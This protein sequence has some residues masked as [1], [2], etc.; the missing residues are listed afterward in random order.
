MCVR[1][2]VTQN[3][4][5]VTETKCGSLSSHWLPPEFLYDLWIRVCLWSRNLLLR[6]TGRF[7]SMKRPILPFPSRLVS[8]GSGSRSCSYRWVQFNPKTHTPNTR[9][10]LFK[11]HV[12]NLLSCFFFC[13]LNWAGG[14]CTPTSLSIASFFFCT[15]RLYFVP[16][17]DEGGIV[18]R[19]QFGPVW[20]FS[21]CKTQLFFKSD[22]TF[23]VV[24]SASR[25]TSFEKHLQTGF[26]D[27]FGNDK[28][29]KEREGEMFLSTLGWL[30]KKK[31]WQHAKNI[32]KCSK[33]PCAYPR[34]YP[35]HFRH[36]RGC[37]SA[38]T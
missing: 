17:L 27:V 13:F 36:K 18:T 21:S 24:V 38:I 7:H 34:L 37:R 5:I 6:A 4:Y 10:F 3:M 2:G 16:V 22:V 8:P 12:E 9:V 23:S 28:R 15:Q 26:L 20:L 35:K 32:S 33:L 30:T 25:Q 19:L 14:T 11:N 1:G 29:E 31:W